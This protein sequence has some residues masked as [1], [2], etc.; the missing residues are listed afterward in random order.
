MTHEFTRPSK[1]LL[2]KWLVAV[3]VPVV[4]FLGAFEAVSWRSSSS[5]DIFTDEILYTRV[6][7]RIAGEGAL[8][9]DSGTAFMVHP[10]LYFL[11]EGAYLSLTG[12][13]HSQVLDPG[14]IY[15][16]VYNARLLNAIFA[17]LTAV[18]LYWLAR[19]LRGIWPGLLIVALFIIDPFGVRI[20]RRAMLE[21]MAELVTFVGMGL[22]ALNLMHGKPKYSWSLWAGLLLG[23]GLLTKE[24]T[25]TSLLAVALFGIWEFFR[26]GLLKSNSGETRYLFSV[27]ALVVI[28]TALLTYGVYPLWVISEGQWA[29]FWAEKYLGLQRLLGLIQ[30]TGWNR[31]GVSLAQFLLPRLTDY[32]S[33]YILLALGGAATLWTLINQRH[34]PQGR[35]IASG[36]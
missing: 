31:P 10:P 29:A 14:N 16:D 23:A 11:I 18:A 20:N 34:A 25:F 9:W 30:I 2:L 36:G 27:H 26:S 13:P 19:R 6:G 28:I 24:L 33:S 21:T 15:T 32:G 7:T 1:G 4:I 35:L 17:G 22:F 12:S 8:V 5:P 3:L